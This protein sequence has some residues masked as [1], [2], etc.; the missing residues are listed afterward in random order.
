VYALPT[1]EDPHVW[2]LTVGGEP[3]VRWRPRVRVEAAM[4]EGRFHGPQL[5]RVIAGGATLLWAR[6]EDPWSDH[7]SFV[8]GELPAR[9]DALPAV[10]LA[11]QRRAP[12]TAG[13]VAWWTHW[14]RH[15]ADALASTPTAVLQ[16]G[17]YALAALVRPLTLR[18]NDFETLP[19]ADRFGAVEF[20]RR[21]SAHDD[22]RVSMWR[23]RAR[24]GIPP[25]LFY[26]WVCAPGPL[27]VDGHDR[28]LAMAL[29]GVPQ[30]ALQLTPT[31]Y[32]GR[33]RRLVGGTAWGETREA[34]R[35]AVGR[36]CPLQG[37]AS[38]W[39]RDVR[40]RTWAL[41]E[42]LDARVRERLLDR[43]LDGP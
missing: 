15:V 5:L 13:S 2:T 1:D 32:G 3:G 9:T 20:T 28:L 39:Y 22:R 24:E 19:G 10:T 8:R 14:L 7:A 4:A 37:G 38:A 21:P 27:L 26:E 16:P 31:A 29:E 12:Q 23:K 30:Y 40:D 41:R 18:V 25:A 34:Q 11:D 6:R 36:L 43:V 33:G 35:Y 42:T 17:T